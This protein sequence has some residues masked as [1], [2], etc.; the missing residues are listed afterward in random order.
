M[1]NR[2]ERRL[3]YEH[4][5]LPEHLP[6]YVEPVSGSEPYLHD[7]YLCFYRKN[8]LTFI[9]YP[10]GTLDV[11]TPKAY[12]SACQRFLPAT[13][14]I[15][16]PEIWFSDQTYKD[17]GKDTYYRLDLPSG[18]QDP[19]VAYM[20]RRAKRELRVTRGIF[21]REHKRLVKAFVSGHALSQEQIAVFQRIPHYL[22]RSVT[23]HILEARKGNILVAF[24]VVEMGSAKYAFYVF[25]F[26]LLKEHVPGA[27]D[28]LFLEMIRLAQAEGKA[29]I[30]LGLGIHSGIRRFKEKWGGVPFV[31]YASALIQRSSAGLGT[32]ASKL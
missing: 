16:A 21:G 4:A 29:A 18:P 28:L 31:P 9:G 19:E 2:D 3:I 30:N 11:D 13:V 5:Y 6:H 7:N 12:E 15:I 10:L 32:L 20:V 24:N 17:Q 22:K 25:N 27:S 1:L 14:A 26:R 8:H 23:A